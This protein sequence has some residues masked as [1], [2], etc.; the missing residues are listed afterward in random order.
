MRQADLNYFQ[1]P[2][3]QTE[4]TTDVRRN[5]T[6]EHQENIPGT[7][8]KG[9][10]S[11]N[12]FRQLVRRSNRYIH[13]ELIA[14][15]LAPRAGLEPLFVGFQNLIQFLSEGYEL[16]PILF[17]HN[18]RAK[19]VNAVAIGFVHWRNEVLQLP[20]VRYVRCRT[21]LERSN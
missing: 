21:I 17:L 1:D 8:V 18:Q 11:G 2:V 9:R 12:L 15:L 7:S 10:K 13:D 14:R 20:S 16:C 5:K 19:L 3:I 4:I 6:V